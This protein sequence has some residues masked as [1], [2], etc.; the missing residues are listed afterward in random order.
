MDDLHGRTRTD[1]DGHGRTRTDTDL[2]RLIRWF[3]WYLDC[4]VEELARRA[5]VNESSVRRWA[6]GTTTPRRANVE[7]LA[8][9]A[10]LRMTFIEAVVLPGIAAVRLAEASEEEVFRDLAE[11]AREFDSSLAGLGRVA[12]TELVAYLEAEPEVERE[13]AREQCNRL[14][15]R[16]A[17]DLW[18]L[19]EARP[20]FQTKE[21]ALLLALESADAASDDAGRAL[22]LARVAHRA[23]QLAGG[24]ALEGWTLAFGMNALR[25]SNEMQEAKEILVRAHDRWQAG[26]EA[27]R[28]MLPGWRLLDL[29]AS[30]CRDQRQFSRALDLLA[31]A[32]A[33]A[34]PEDL[35][36]ILVK[37]AVTLEHMGDAEGAI[38]VLQ[39]A[40]PLAERQGDSRLVF[41][42]LANLGAN[43]CHLDRYG[44]AEELLPR[45]QELA[46]GSR[47]ELDELRMVWLRARIDAGQGRAAE[48]R[49]GFDQVRS[50]F[51][52]REMG[53]DYA[54]ASLERAELD[55]RE[56]RTAEV[57]ALAEEMAWIFKK[58]GIH[59]EALAA[60]GLFRAAAGREEATAEMAGRMVRYLY[61]ARREPGLKFGG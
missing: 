18:Y 56:G 23:A 8:E 31:K 2:Q 60:L 33:A 34:P 55:L 16:E 22:L 17:D 45:I 48:A 61:R 3:C 53:Y 14:K 11:A 15:S 25:V 28:A 40:A 26:D 24:V 50:G 54:L 20:E 42:I 51:E 47:K 49:S 57:K 41:R 4:S 30:L 36:R 13:D 35:P 1:T 46:A 6:K 12:V 59:R 39:E 37:R 5:G 19:I 27:E 10:G 21:L 32:E 43:L 9:A 38:E 29:E 52:E 7:K 58:K 44:E